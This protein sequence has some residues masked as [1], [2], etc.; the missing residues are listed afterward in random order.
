[1]VNTERATDPGYLRFQYGD[2][3]RLRIRADTHRLYSE[4]PDD[5]V[6]WMLDQLEPGPGHLVLDVG[7]GYG[8]YHHALARRGARAIVGLDASVAM[9]EAA[10]QRAAAHNLTVIAIHGDAQRLPLPTATYDRAMA[11]HMLFH[12]TDQLAALRELR[13]VLKPAGRVLLATNAAD[14]SQQLW[15]LHAAAAR[16]LGYIPAAPVSA[17]FHLDHLGL[18]QQVFPTAERRVR[19]DA[20]VFPTAEAVLRY[21]ASGLVDAI[22]D[23]P[24]DG[25]HRAALL[26][27]MG[28]QVEAIIRSEGVFRVAKDA[29]CFVADR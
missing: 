23:P 5:F 1:V 22:V 29:G 20:F 11:N 24:A 16:Q 12:V 14:H 21:M 17:R 15:D 8:I 4:R 28:D 18:V 10:Q 7:R 27:L 19:S 25:S 2:T 3:E 6:D 26:A 9:V 13:R